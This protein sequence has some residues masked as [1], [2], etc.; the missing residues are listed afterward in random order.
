M[1]SKENTVVNYYMYISKVT[2]YQAN[3]KLQYISLYYLILH[4]GWLPKRI[5]VNLKSILEVL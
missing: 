3:I 4:A 2:Y 5:K 1:S